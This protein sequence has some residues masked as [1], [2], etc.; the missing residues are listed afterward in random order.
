MSTVPLDDGPRSQR[1][2]GPFWIEE[3]IGLVVVGA[4]VVVVV[5]V[6]YALA[7]AQRPA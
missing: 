4:V 6:L 1:R 5:A 7:V 3:G 2:V